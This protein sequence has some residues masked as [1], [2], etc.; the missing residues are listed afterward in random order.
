[1]LLKYPGISKR[2]SRPNFVALFFLIPNPADLESG[3]LSTINN[4]AVNW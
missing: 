3:S 2:T 1:M 4:A